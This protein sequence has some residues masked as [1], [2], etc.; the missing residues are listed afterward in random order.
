MYNIHNLGQ[1]DSKKKVS[2]L[3]KI[4]SKNKKIIQKNIYY[5]KSNRS[6]LKYLKKNYVK[7]WYIGKL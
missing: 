3:I 1:S 4:S 2:R 6:V 7:F 5:N